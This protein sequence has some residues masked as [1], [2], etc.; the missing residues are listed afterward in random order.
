MM[1]TQGKFHINPESGMA[2]RCFATLRGCRYGSYI[3]HFDTESEA[4]KYAESMMSEQFGSTAKISNNSRNSKIKTGQMIEAERL[5]DDNIDNSYLKRIA[6][7]KTSNTV[8][9]KL[10]EALLL[11]QSDSKSKVFRAIAENDVVKDNDLMRIASLQNK[12]TSEVSKKTR[13][14]KLINFF[15]LNKY[16]DVRNNTLKNP[17]VTA[18]ETFAVTLKYPDTYYNK[19]VMEKLEN[20]GFDTSHIYNDVN[21]QQ[22]KSYKGEKT[23]YVRVAKAIDDL[24]VKK[25]KANATDDEIRAEITERFEKMN[26]ISDMGKMSANI[27]EEMDAYVN[28]S[29]NHARYASKIEKHGEIIL[30]KRRRMSQEYKENYVS[31][32]PVGRPR[33]RLDSE[34]NG[35]YEYTPNLRRDKIRDEMPTETKTLLS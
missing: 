32:R 30:A 4:Q 14:K 18:A 34:G 17:H 25:V 31:T 12:E 29:I 28:L 22:G 24:V 10:S 19:K 9:S 35:Y 7:Y 15:L 13:N 11:K 1:K 26:F 20:N 8:Q 6:N 16:V 23:D 2:G 33:G 27:D 5:K 21:K 3:P